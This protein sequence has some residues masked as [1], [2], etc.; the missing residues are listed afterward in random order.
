[1]KANVL[2][3][4]VFLFFRMTTGLS[5]DYS[6]LIIAVNMGDFASFKEQLDPLDDLD[7]I[8]V[9]GYT[10][11]N[12]SILGR[13]KDFVEYL[14]GRD[15]DL[16][17]E[18]RGLTP[19][20][21][22]A[23][24]NTEILKILIDAGADINGEI[25]QRTALSVAIR[26]NRK[27]AIKILESN[28]ATIDLR[29]GVDGPYVFYDSLN[30]STILISVNEINRLSVDTLKIMPE[31]L[32][33]RTPDH[34]SFKVSLYEP[35]LENPSVYSETDKIFAISDIEGNFEELTATLRNNGVIDKDFG[36]DFGQG[37]LVL[38]GDFIDR[39]KHVTQLL[40]LIFKLEQE[41]SAQGGKVHY[42][43]GN[44][45]LMNMAGDIRYVNMRYKILA[46][47]AGLDIGNFHTGQVIIGDWLRTKNVI[48]KIGDFVFVHAGISDTLIKMD[49]SIPEI[50]E[51][52]WQNF[53]IPLDELP[54]EAITVLSEQ[55]V[56]WYR[57]YTAE[58][59]NYDKTTLETVDKTLNYFDAGHIVVGHSIVRDISTDYEG[60]IIRIDVDHRDHP[61][62]GIL[63]TPE[64]VYKAMQ[65]GK[66]ELILERN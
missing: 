35:V 22:A 66:K 37:H 28:G 2:L 54:E 40:W 53:G 8:V 30:S 4:I 36:W 50:N 16:D 19:L 55:G 26:E 1:M 10:L 43:L 6:A 3:V 58:G 17:K 52:A 7:E 65:N 48:E 41:A 64:G 34:G 45:E 51:L 5:Q 14:I 18:S 49:L 38:L 32:R 57:G 13:H 27:K 44:H 42:L 15:V 20:M 11:L 12:Y 56:L 39:G 29:D 47:K 23:R 60:K 62:S 33:V 9:N 59:S 25:G 46:Y 21:N 61:S 63:I 24:Q 31:E